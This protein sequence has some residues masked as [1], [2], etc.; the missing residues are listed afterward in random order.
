MTELQMSSPVSRYIET[1][2]TLQKMAGEKARQQQMG[3]RHGLA[4]QTGQARN[5]L[6]GIEKQAGQQ[7]Q[8]ESLMRDIAQGAAYADT[9]EKWNQ[10]IDHFVGRGMK[11]AEQ[12]R[13]QFE[14]RDLFIKLGHPQTRSAAV[15]EMQDIAERGGFSPEDIKSQAR[16][17][18]GLEPRKV[19]SAIQTISALGTEEGIAKTEATLAAGKEKGKLK[20]QLEYRPRIQAAIK[21]SEKEATE[22]GEVLTDLNR[23]EASLPGIK[24][25]VGELREL[26]QIA[27]STIG[28]KIFDLAVKESGFGSTKG[29]TARA[30]F[31]AIIDNQVLP[32]LK[33][34]FGAAFTVQEGE[35]LKATMGDPDSP[36]EEKM[37]Q[38][39]AFIAQKERDIRS[40]KSQLGEGVVLQHPEYGDITEDDIITT[41]KNHDL[42]RDQVM[43][44]LGA[45]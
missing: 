1:T 17:K 3:E 35:N 28:G 36:P 42:T 15:Q 22:K 2:G 5:E 21:L 33:E 31:I 34:T 10:V 11:S 30:K 13:D 44:R 32:L 43:Q 38:L 40:K 12:Y 25:A 39:E 41:M 9:P 23:M 16:I 29:G 18:A 4:M 6:L 24:E 37:A 7:R 27:T 14:M 20:E 19:G 26:S 45:Q 8:Q